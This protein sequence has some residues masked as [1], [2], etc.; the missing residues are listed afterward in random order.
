[1]N[2]LALHQSTLCLELHMVA[3]EEQL[4]PHTLCCVLSVC[5]HYSSR[6]LSNLLT[7]FA[8]DCPALLLFFLTLD[9]FP[10]ILS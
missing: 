10:L 1:M 3:I 4:L 5:H 9:N 6:Q 8:I 2:V 7:I